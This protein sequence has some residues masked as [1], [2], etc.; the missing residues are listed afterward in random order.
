VKR[1]LIIWAW[2]GVVVLA[3][4]GALVVYFQPQPR[5]DKETLDRI[6]PGMTEKEVENLIGAPPGR[7]CDFEPMDTR[8]QQVKGDYKKEWVG[9]DLIICV[10]FS[11]GKVVGKGLGYVTGSMPKASWWERM[12]S[13][14]GF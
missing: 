9:N 5:I 8:V 14:L 11:D 4:A 7:Y 2:V 3:V 13:W 1:R 6:T 10:G 12:T